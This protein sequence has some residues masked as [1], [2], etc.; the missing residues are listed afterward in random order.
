MKMSPALFSSEAPL[1]YLAML[2]VSVYLVDNH[3]QP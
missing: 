2:V 1:I 3:G